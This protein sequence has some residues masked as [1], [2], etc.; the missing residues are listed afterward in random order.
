[1]QHVLREY[2]TAVVAM[3]TSFGS[4]ILG[5]IDAVPQTPWSAVGYF[6]VAFVSGTVAAVLLL[7]KAWA[8][9]LQAEERLAERGVTE[10][11]I[12]EARTQLGRLSGDQRELL[13]VLLLST[14]LTG[15]QIHARF[16]DGINVNLINRDTPFLELD[17]AVGR[18]SV[19]R[20]W[21]GVL[22]ELLVGPPAG[23]TTGLW[24]GR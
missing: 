13:R 5:L 9:A 23:V 12:Q 14:H 8:R 7:R 1:M 3:A 11:R 24:R 19:H 6:V 2:W 18:W 16:P 4:F 21:Q 22:G 20:Q 15:P 10:A 17:E